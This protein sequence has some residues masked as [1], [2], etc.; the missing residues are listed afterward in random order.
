MRCRAAVVADFRVA[1]LQVFLEIRACCFW[2]MSL[3]CAVCG[4]CAACIGVVHAHNVPGG[5]Y[6]YFF[7]E[8]PL[9]A[10][11]E[12]YGAETLA[13][14]AIGDQN[15]P[16]GPGFLPAPVPQHPKGA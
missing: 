13:C 11:L 4:L 9:G 3:V 12:I 15:R 7:E 10:P 6:I 2:R 16:E 8:I 14:I 1:V 5:A